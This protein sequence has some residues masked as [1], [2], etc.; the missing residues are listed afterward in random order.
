MCDELGRE[1]RRSSADS[2]EQFAPRR[3]DTERVA[4]IAPNGVPALGQTD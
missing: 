1:P 3:G 4:K 2:L